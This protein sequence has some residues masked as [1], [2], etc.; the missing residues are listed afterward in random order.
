MTRRKTILCA[1]IAAM[2]PLAARAEHTR[3]WRQSDYGDFAR[4]TATGVAIRSDGKITAAPRF[5]SF[6]D[7]SMSFL[8]TLRLDPQGR[9]YAAGGSDAKVLRFDST[10]KATT[11]FE[12]SDLG[13]QAIAFDSKGNLYVGTSP[14]GKVYKVTPD[15]AKTVF[16]DPK[17]KYIWSLA[18]DREGDV[19]VGTGDKGEIFVVTPDGTGKS[20]YQSDQR[21]ARALAFDAKGDL[22]VGTEPDGLILRIPIV[23]KSASAAPEPGSPFVLY[24]TSKKEV[25]SLLTDS[26]G[27]IYAAAIG[28]KTRNANVP[29]APV[30]SQTTT[31]QVTAS[32]SAPSAPAAQITPNV[33]AEPQAVVVQPNIPASFLGAS[34][35]GAE[36]VKIAPD[37]SPQ[38]LWTSRDQIVLSLAL[39]PDGKLLL[40]TGN[41][42]DIVRLEG[43]RVYSDIE[44]TSA[45]QVTSLIPAPDGRIYAATANPGK[46]F[47]IGPGSQPD[48]NFV[49]STY[50]AS[51]FSR[52]GRLTWWG[53]DGG[54]QGRVAFYVRSGNTSNPEKN[55]GPWTGPYKSASG[56]T[57][58]CPSARF[59]QWKAVF[60]QGEGGD[61][62]SISWVSLAY[63]PKNVA[64]VIDAIALQDPGI[65]V[66]GFQQVGGNSAPVQ[67]RIP[68]RGGSDPS[69]Q[70]NED[71]GQN[72][73]RV[74]IL[75]QAVADHGYQS[76]LWN[77]HDDN[78]DTLTYSIY[79][80]GEGEKNW[81]LLKDKISEEYYS[82]DTSTMPDGA[83]YLKIVASDAPSNPPDEALTAERES[84]R[85]LVGNTP[86]HVDDLHAQTDGESTTLSFG[87][88]S[89]SGAISRASYSIDSQSWEIVFPIGQ[90]TDAPKED[91]QWKVQGLSAGEHTVSVRVTDHFGNETA[92]KTTFTIAGP[93]T[94]AAISAAR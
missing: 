59:V 11:V 62:P 10:G 57:V 55:W 4:G 34:A 60:L 18:V 38:E 13:A 48:G 39:S 87:A 28:E 8:W 42:G 41:H 75:P 76:V 61:Q 82:W 46:I 89:T 88:T 71:E 86:P 15:G 80:R 1:L 67:L 35:T 25:T 68:S 45:M 56:E 37:D 49:S 50:D 53:E 66:S 32:A 3:F 77:A 83:Y 40:G 69:S 31:I 54:A 12:S 30:A 73:A 63:Q 23:R 2:V 92:A 52:W 44:Q 36:I 7:P 64:P 65:R 43:N 6:A 29:V 85:F 90:L 22:L 26:S 84:D 16:F 5:S 9:L 93:P 91:Y 19:F 17:A 24:E 47:A 74:Q 70:G 20:F 79:I 51:I 58:T 14:D 27:N 81:R 33:E 94:T 78:D 72:Q 21:H